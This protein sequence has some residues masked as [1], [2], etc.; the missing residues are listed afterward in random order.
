LAMTAFFA[1]SAIANPFAAQNAGAGRM[2]RVAEGVRLSML[3]CAVFGLAVAV[4]L[5]FA[6]G[7][8]VAQF[9]A[10][11]AVAASAAM[12]LR[13]IPWGFGAVGVIAVVSATLNGLER[14]LAAVG[15][16]LGRT[17]VIGVPLAWLGGA[18]VGEAG[19]LMGILLSGLIVGGVAAAYLWRVVAQR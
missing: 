1:L 6:S 14:P 3:F 16:S 8:I 17:F 5:W 4:P 18:L 2:D 12:Y 10:D 13:I 15:V 19:L 9:T 11:P 7:W